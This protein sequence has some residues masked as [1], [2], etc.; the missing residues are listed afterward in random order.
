V[1]R[2]LSLALVTVLLAA[3]ALSACGS[4]DAL[5]GKDP[6]GVLSETFGPDHP[7]KSGRLDLGLKLDIKGLQGL[8]GPINARL[9]G[10]FQTTGGKS[11]PAFNLK[12]T[13]DA[14]GQAF[15]AGAV[16]TGKNG[17]ISIAG[18]SYDV[19]ASL[20]NSLQKG[21][22]DASKPATK[23]SGPTFSS[24]GIQ[25]LHWLKDPNK[26][27][28][29][30]LAGVNTVHVTAQVDVAKLLVDIDT[31]LSKAGNVTVP[32]TTGKVPSGLTAAQRNAIVTAVKSTTFDVWAGKADGTLRRLR[33]GVTFDVPKNQQVNTGGLQSGTIALDLAI[34]ALNVKQ[35]ITG[36]TSSRPISELTSALQQATGTTTSADTGTTSTPAPTTTSTTPSSGGAQSKYLTCLSAAGSDLAKVQKC[37]SLIGR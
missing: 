26:A 3:L 34:G 36:P 37:A 13:L 9:S 32:G 14:G 7:V 11:L 18:Q 15:T 1:T 8:S 20:F 24:L 6:A 23:T 10:P 2:R 29:E 5:D 12:L 28:E 21:Y 22:K 30:D 16:S 4:S 31:L 19:G 35:Q 25:P 33:V 27:G 17:Y